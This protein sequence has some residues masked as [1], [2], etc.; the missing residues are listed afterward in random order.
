MK[1][2]ERNDTTSKSQKLLSPF[3]K[4]ITHLFTDISC[5]RSTFSNFTVSRKRALGEIVK[6]EKTCW[7]HIKHVGIS[8][9]CTGDTSEPSFYETSVESL[10]K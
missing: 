6:L 9:F 1:A 5:E 4:R 2:E 3:H 7:V 10:D 8:L